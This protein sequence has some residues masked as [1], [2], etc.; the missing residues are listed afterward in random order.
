MRILVTGS[1]GFLGVVL[2]KMLKRNGHEVVPFDLLNGQNIL[3]KKQLSS[4]LSN[5]QACIHL[6]AIADLYEAEDAPEKTYQINV[7]ATNVLLDLAEEKKIRLLFASTVCAYG[8]NGNPINQEDSPLAPTEVYAASKVMAEALFRERLEKHAILR[9]ATFYGPGMRSSLATSV[10]LKAIIHGQEVNIH[11]DGQQT[12]CYTHVEDIASGIL[13]VLEADANGIFNIS[14]EQEVSVVEL[15]QIISQ[16]TGKEAKINFVE[17]RFGQIFQSRNS[18][19]KLK[20]LGW[21]PKYNLLS[22]LETCL[23]E[24]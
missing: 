20:S 4:A 8:N 24:Y 10:F 22:G 21:S 13:A 16:L 9:L 5:C 18:I 14:A 11:G 12:R 17:E 19:E 1:E 2:C 15:I 6:A 3:D 23:L 7:E